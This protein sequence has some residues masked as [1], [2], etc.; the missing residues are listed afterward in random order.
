MFFQDKLAVSKRCATVVDTSAVREYQV[1]GAEHT[2]GALQFL[3]DCFIAVKRPLVRGRVLQRVTGKRRVTAKAYV[4]PL[5]SHRVMELI[6]DCLGSVLEDDNEITAI[7]SSQE[8][9][10]RCGLGRN[11]RR[12]SYG[13]HAE[14]LSAAEYVAFACLDVNA[15]LDTMAEARRRP[16]PAQMQPT[17]EENENEVGLAAEF[18]EVGGSDS[19]HVDADDMD[20]VPLVKPDLQYQPRLHVDQTDVLT[21]AHRLNVQT[22]GPGRKSAGVQR[23]VEFVKQYADKYKEV[24]TPRL[25][26]RSD[27]GG[28]DP[29]S[30]PLGR[31][32]T[33]THLAFEHQKNLLEE[34][35]DKDVKAGVDSEDEFVAGGMRP[36]VAVD[37]APFAKVLI[38][39]PE[40]K[41]MQLLQQK[42]PVAVDVAAGSFAI[43][44]DQY[45][46]VLLAIAP[47]Q[48]LWDKAQE[49]Q[50]LACFGDPSQADKLLDLVTPVTGPLI[51]IVFHFFLRRLSM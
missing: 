42:L 9:F 35:K 22:G 29:V 2:S 14:Q 20:Q 28:Y 51:V 8:H 43:S 31:G 37:V 33:A 24:Q 27:A 16:R 46:V 5:F 26:Q 1:P 6:L 3:L 21:L 47:L 12:T 11:T 36:E 10:D 39:S 44:P 45:N 40:E 48:R 18:V 32:A 13:W 41:A 7:G 23:A 4:M 30:F 19:E 49:R 50:M 34:R 15:H 17:V 38:L 25:C